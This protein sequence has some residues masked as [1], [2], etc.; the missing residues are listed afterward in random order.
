MLSEFKASLGKTNSTSEQI[1]SPSLQEIK[2]GL[3]AGS[4]SLSLLMDHPFYSV[5]SMEMLHERGC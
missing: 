1:E 4:N 3:V 2:Q 5:R